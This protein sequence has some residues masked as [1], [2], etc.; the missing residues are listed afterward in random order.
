M[1]W[2]HGSFH[3]GAVFFFFFFTQKPPSAK[4]N[5]RNGRI[6]SSGRRRL[7]LVQSQLPSTSDRDCK[8][9]PSHLDCQ[10]ITSL[11]RRM[12]GLIIKL[13]FWKCLK[14]GGV[15]LVWAVCQSSVCCLFLIKK[16]MLSLFNMCG[17]SFLFLRGETSQTHKIWPFSANLK[18]GF[19]L[20]K[21]IYFTFV[22]TV[23]NTHTHPQAKIL[24][25]SVSLGPVYV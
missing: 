2:T 4:T 24:H 11:K 17:F 5:R 15:T 12:G 3:A 13:G 21:Q 25:C 6:N 8:L 14:I 1:R 18:C 23:Q 19:S 16:D 20:N 7:A 22:C 9:V 10:G